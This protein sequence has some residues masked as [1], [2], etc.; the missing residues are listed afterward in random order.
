LA[1]AFFPIARKL[2]LK[3]F[4]IT[5]SAQNALNPAPQRILFEKGFFYFQTSGI[6]KMKIP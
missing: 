4:Q 3:I 6:M 1:E 2:A 5:G